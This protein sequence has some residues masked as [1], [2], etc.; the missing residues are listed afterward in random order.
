MLLTEL[1]G[2][3][4]MD[5]MFEKRVE[6]PNVCVRCILESDRSLLERHIRAISFF[7]ILPAIH[8]MP[9]SCAKEEAELAKDPTCL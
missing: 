7:A 9:I 3:Y 6:A 2:Q 1:L 5:A 8:L 4:G